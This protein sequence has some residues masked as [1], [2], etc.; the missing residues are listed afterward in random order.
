MPAPDGPSSAT[1]SLHCHHAAPGHSHLLAPAQA[2]QAPS[3]AAAWGGLMHSRGCHSCCQHQHRAGSAP[4]PPHHQEVLTQQSRS[5]GPPPLA[6]ISHSSTLPSTAGS[7]FLLPSSNRKL[8][9]TS[10]GCE[11]LTPGAATI[12]RLPS[13]VQAHAKQP[14]PSPNPV[15]LPPLHRGS[16]LAP[17]SC[18]TQSLQQLQ[19]NRNPA[20]SQLR[21]KYTSISAPGRDIPG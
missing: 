3:A 13:W 18:A 15:A 16:E 7:S 11:R 4:F 9:R 1:S 14:P 21:H 20:C 6:D 2:R 19:F 5:P 10:Q 12:L 8:P 17:A